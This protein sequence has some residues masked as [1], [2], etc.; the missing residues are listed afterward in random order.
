MAPFLL[1]KDIALRSW[2]K[3]PFAYY[4]RGENLPHVIDRRDFTTLLYCDGTEDIEENEITS[5]LLK[6][7]IIIRKENKDE[8]LLSWQQFR[9]CNNDVTPSL[10]IEITQRC[11]CNCRHCFNA[12]GN[13]T[14]KE[15]LTFENILKIL[16]DAQKCGVFALTITGGEPL[17]RKDF[18]DIVDA[19]DE[20]GMSIRELNTNGSFLTTDILDHFK[21]HGDKPLIKISFDGIGYHDALRGNPGMEEKSLYSIKLAVKSGF[22]VM[23]QMNINKENLS[24]II[25]SLEMLDEIGVSTTRIIRTIETPQ[26]AKNGVSATLSWEEYYE[27]V[28]NILKDYC[29]KD[30]KMKIISWLFLTVD[31]VSK[32]Y[33]T[34][35]EKFT[36]KKYNSRLPLCSAC[37]G[38]PAIG[39]SGKI[40]PCMQMSGYFDLK[41]IDDG[42]VL[43][44]ELIELLNKGAYHDRTYMTVEERLSKNEKCRSCSHYEK[45]AGGCPALG[46]LYSGQ[47][48]H[49]DPSKCLIYENGFD[50]KA[51]ELLTSLGYDAK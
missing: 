24:T 23:V 15:E 44:T 7:G 49:Y 48:A 43:K 40:Y 26:W 6:E 11:D 32:S 37:K 3:L 14:P 13:N 27:N 51:A 50:I 46:L 31:P 9:Y 25:P 8:N 38:M 18:K 34:G 1:N 17:I 16:D 35:Y 41:G 20:R 2:N 12:T 28:L 33:R 21:E 10:N 45:C 5:K 19:I 36:T 47:Y 42:N 39:S 30:H 4:R 22:Q 29:S